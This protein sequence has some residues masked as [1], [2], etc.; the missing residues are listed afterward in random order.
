MGRLLN[1]RALS[2]TDQYDTIFV[3]IVRISIAGWVKIVTEIKIIAPS[4]RDVFNDN[5]KIH[6]LVKFAI[7]C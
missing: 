4:L 2:Q 6:S 5:I 1:K 3:Q 7:A